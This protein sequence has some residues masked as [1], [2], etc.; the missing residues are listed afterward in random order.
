MNL[1]HAEVAKVLV[2]NPDRFDEFRREYGGDHE[3]YEKVLSKCPTELETFDEFLSLYEILLERG[4]RDTVIS[5]LERDLARS[6]KNMVLGDSKAGKAYPIDTLSE[7]S[8][9]VA[10]FDSLSEQV[11]VPSERDIV[12]TTIEHIYAFES[13]D[14]RSDE[15]FDRLLADTDG[16]DDEAVEVLARARLVARLRDGI[17]SEDQVEQE[18]DR[19]LTATV[20]PMP[21]DDQSAEE[22]CQMIESARLANPELPVYYLAALHRRPE[23][24]L[25]WET[26]Y[27]QARDVVER[28]R[29][30][31]R[32]QPTRCELLLTTRQL[33]VVD[34][35]TTTNWGAEQTA[36]VRSYRDVARAICATGGRWQSGREP[37]RWPAPDFDTATEAYFSAAEAIEGF[38]DARFVKYTSKGIRHA[39]HG[40]DDWQARTRVHEYA[41]VLF[42][43]LQLRND[44]PPSVEETIESAVTIHEYRAAVARAHVQFR[45]GAFVDVIETVEKATEL[46]EELPQRTVKTT[47]LELLTPLASARLA[48]AD[49]EFETARERYSL[50]DTPDARVELR[51]ALAEIKACL[52]RGDETNAVR[53]ADEHFADSSLITAAVYAVAGRRPPTEPPYEIPDSLPSANETSVSVLP[54]LIGLQSQAL[55]LEEPLRDI[56]KQTI[57]EL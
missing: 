13:H 31:D 53:I 26:L 37:N 25:L 41:K 55:P 36:Y 8:D 56:I 11:T 21:D 19:Y 32:T 6:I 4:P 15:L 27:V 40:T 10:Q 18:L 54:L 57:L 52:E 28:F 33:S 23:I 16:V 29:H 43:D 44:F 35:C 30:G 45:A 34:R 14:R 1:T 42:Y 17:P 24:G 51:R 2:N 47:E 39:A 46:R 7:L 22:L 38:D 12:L 20:D 3:L 50:I 49:G 48:E 9:R 5:N